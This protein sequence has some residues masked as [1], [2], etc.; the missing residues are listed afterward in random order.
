M[1]EELDY[2][3]EDEALNAHQQQPGDADDE[4]GD[5]AHQD[6]G[7]GQDMGRGGAGDF[8][9]SDHQ[10]T[11]VEGLGTAASLSPPPG[12]IMQAALASPEVVPEEWQVMNVPE[13]WRPRPMLRIWGLPAAATE[14]E[15]AALLE[16]QGLEHGVRSV[17]FDPRQTTAAGKVALVRFDPPPAPPLGDHGAP[18]PE[19]DVG[20]V[21]EGLIAALRAKAPQLH[22]VKLNVE[23][24]GAE[25]GAGP[26][27]WQPSWPAWLAAA[28]DAE[29]Q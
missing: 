26:A 24:T 19:P 27:A 9:P 15:L 12:S 18:L 11:D 2:E 28:A 29:A 1:D 6:V 17:A 23:K 4:Q 10:R 16:E 20:K 25:V 14:D 13:E 22:G 3:L 5:G 8:P 7:G 21:A